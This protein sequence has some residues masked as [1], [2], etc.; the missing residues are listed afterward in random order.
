M[1]NIAKAD[2]NHEFSRGADIWRMLG[3][4]WTLLILHSVGTLQVV[5]FTKIKKNLG[6][7]SG[8]MLSEGLLELER[9]G[10]VTKMIHGAVPPKIEYRLTD[11]AREL[12]VIL[13]ELDGWHTRWKAPVNDEYCL[14]TN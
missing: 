6:C 8:T 7:I 4:K 5:R 14:T 11:S 12:E 9:E 1:S 10:L 2:G 13:K 3:K